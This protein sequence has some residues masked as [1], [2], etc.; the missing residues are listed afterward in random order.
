L[1][2]EERR[3]N[4]T[5]TVWADSIHLPDAVSLR[6]PDWPGFIYSRHSLLVASCRVRDLL[7]AVF[8][9]TLS[10]TYSTEAV[11]EIKVA[12]LK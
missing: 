3:I 7:Q 2:W 1:I 10:D 12:V 5:G 6:L 8:P 11:F 4:K 9:Y